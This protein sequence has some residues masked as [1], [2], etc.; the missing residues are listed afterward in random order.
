MIRPSGASCTARRSSAINP[1]SPPDR[2][3]I[4]PM[5]AP[6]VLRHPV[7]NPEWLGKLSEDILEPDLPIVDPHHHL[8]DHPGNKY[9][10]HE[11]LADVNSGHN[12]VSTVFLQC[13]WA[14]RTDGPEEMKPVGE[15]E[16]VA[17]VAAEAERR[18]TRTKICAGIVG[19]LD[20]RIGDRVNDVLQAHAAAGAGRF[21]G[22]RQITARHHR[23]LASM[24]T[25]PI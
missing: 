2:L 15:T 20:F 18:G 21:R 12:I 11:L 8:W 25:P 6:V 10:L 1:S 14:Y 16:F 22:I 13:F 19:H 17:S 5:T 3:E 4:R 24:A 23:I 9:Y 7:P